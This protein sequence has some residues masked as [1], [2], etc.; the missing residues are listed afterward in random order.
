V[1]KPNSD[2]SLLS[3][4]E[5]STS[6]ALQISRR[7]FGQYAAAAAGLS[8]SPAQFLAAPHDTHQERHDGVDLTP[9]QT[10]EVDAKLVNIVR[11]YRTRLSDEQCRHLRRI[12][13][14]NEKLLASVRAF[15]LQNGD[16]PAGVLRISFLPEVLPSSKAEDWKT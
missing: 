13:S 12:L 8:L 2:L 5:T 3:Q 16:P 6:D 1:P 9:E 15:P 11:K 4:Q 14:Y 10:R 7:R